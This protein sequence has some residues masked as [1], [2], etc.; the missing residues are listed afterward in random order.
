MPDEFQKDKLHKMGSEL[1]RMKLR[2]KIEQIK[3]LPTLPEVASKLMNMLLDEACSAAQLAKEIANDQSLTAKVLKVVNSAYY[4]FHRQITTLQEAVVILGLEEM[5]RL[6]AT[7]SVFSVLKP[8]TIGTFSRKSLWEHSVAT[9]IAGELI[10]VRLGRS[11]KGIFVCGLL[12]DI[13]KVALD[14]FFH[15]DWEAI[16]NKAQKESVWIGTIEQARFGTT[17]AEVGGWL[18]ER[19]SLPPVIV[20]AISGHHRIQQTDASEIGLWAVIQL[21]DLM[22]RQGH[23]GSGG[24]EA[25]PPTVED[26]QVSLGLSDSDLEKLHEQFQERIQEVIE[27]WDLLKED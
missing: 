10:A 21:A 22:T 18:V 1:A 5:Q 13:G 3:N 12:H 20:D 15:E 9:A 2:A 14:Q 24:D 23:F 25:I 19:W 17:H 16:L 4:G 11:M 6:I 27:S 7:I 8:S 26:L